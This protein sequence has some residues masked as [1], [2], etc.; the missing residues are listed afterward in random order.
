MINAYVVTLV[1][2]NVNKVVG[3]YSNEVLALQAGESASKEYDYDCVYLIDR[4]I[5]DK[6]YGKAY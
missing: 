2:T 3:V 4:V 6:P 1:T 5:V